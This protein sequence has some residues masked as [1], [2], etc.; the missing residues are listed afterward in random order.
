MY[1]CARLQIRYLTAQKIYIAQFNIVIQNTDTGTESRTKPILTLEPTPNHIF[2]FTYL[3]HTRTTH[4]R[5]HD[6]HTT[7]TRARA[8]PKRARRHSLNLP[9]C[10]THQNTFIT[11]AP[12][13]DSSLQQ[14]KT[15]IVAIYAII[16][17]RKSHKRHSQSFD[18]W[19][20]LTL[21]PTHP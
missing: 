8:L 12:R 14:I 9:V 15:L 4:A 7:H 21:K 2:S 18:R 3:L 13:W 20:R 17:I 6:V 19:P 5:T 10:F 1:V 11:I 16:H